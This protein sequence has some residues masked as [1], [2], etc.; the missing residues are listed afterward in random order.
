MN[1]YRIL[2]ILG[3]GSYGKVYKAYNKNDERIV[4]LK[5]VKFDN[6]VNKSLILK[7]VNFLKTISQDGCNPF[8]TCYYGSFEEN[9]KLYIEMEFIDGMDLKEY[10]EGFRVQNKYKELYENLLA[11]AED[12]LKGL[13]F[14]HANG[15]IHRDIRP[16]NIMI[17][18][19][20]IPKIIDVGLSCYAIER[21]T[22]NNKDLDCCVGKAGTPLYMSP[23]VLLE[24]EAYFVS[25]VWSLG[26]SL[27]HSA[28]NMVPYYP[29]P[30]TLKQ[31]T[32]M[33][34][35]EQPRRLLTSNKDLNNLVNK[36]LVKNVLMRPT[37][38]ELLKEL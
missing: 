22:L 13:N 5:E 25:D 30:Y 17:S 21:C 11:I 7:E 31:L 38:L 26:A 2:N 14:L 23:E 32:T 35:S 10:S 28:T 33:M 3:Q 4:A 16:E 12:I 27:L 24:N 36:M 20:N 18:K 8:L 34:I 19:D 29:D 15:I 37:T 6:S 1:N 9:D